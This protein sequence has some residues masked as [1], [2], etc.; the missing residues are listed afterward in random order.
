M[1]VNVLLIDDAKDFVDYM[2]KRLKARGMEVWTAYDGQTGLDVVRKE[3]LDVVV[4][5]VLMPGIDGIETLQEIKTIKPELQVIM[6]TGHGTVETAAE[7]MKLGAADF[8]LKPCDLESLLTSIQKAY[9]KRTQT[10]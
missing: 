4:L 5:D 8:L 1:P 7:G 6:L 10:T 3:Y 2:S 9:E